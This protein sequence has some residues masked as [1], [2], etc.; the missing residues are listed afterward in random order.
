MQ[1][2]VT[3]IGSYVSPYVRKVLAALHLKGIAY[4]IDPIVPFFG[5]ESFTRISPLR[6]IPVL[7]DGDVA[8]CD[9]TVIC[10]YLEEREPLPALLPAGPADRA[11]SRW[12]EEFADT[13]LGD[14]LIWALFDQR[15]IRRAVFGEATDE[16]VVEKAIREDIPSCLDYLERELP[17]AGFLFGSI[18]IADLA[19]AAPFRNA[20]FA[21]FTIDAARWPRSAAFIARVL[22]HSAVA[23]LRSFEE[24]S[25]RIPPPKAREALAAL[26]APICAKTWGEAEPQRGLMRI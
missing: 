13:R 15:V 5:G 2:P 23:R 26:G 6:R 7:I 8:L 17:A 16:A 14:V 20:A 24:A 10:E 1:Q 12:L 4:E 9:S 25:L 11:R 19:I 3:I 21:R 18:G 22:E